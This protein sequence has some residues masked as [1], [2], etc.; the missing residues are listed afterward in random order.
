[1]KM[2]QIFCDVDL[3]KAKGIPLKQFSAILSHLNDVF[4][5]KVDRVNSFKL[6]GT[7][8]VEVEF[9]LIPNLD[10][11][12]YGEYVDLENYIFDYKNAHR[13]MAVLYR[14][15]QYRKGNT[16]HIQRYKGTGHLA[17]V[18][19]EAPLDVFLGVQVFFLQFSEKIRSLYD[20]LYTTA[21]IDERG[22]SLRQGFGKKWGSYQAI[23]TLAQGDVTKFDKVTRINA[24]TALKYLEYIKERTEV[25]NKIMKQSLR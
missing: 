21:V 23:D 20:G 22:G 3:K 11:M 14:P 12:S 16:Y 25:E 7:D 19:K 6:K 15:I 9:G 17:D 13:A 5:E 18:M 24:H 2:L 10:E 4:S 1:M 8:G